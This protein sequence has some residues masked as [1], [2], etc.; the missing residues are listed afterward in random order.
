MFYWLPSDR[1]KIGRVSLI[2]NESLLRS[3]THKHSRLKIIKS[4][5]I[6]HLLHNGIHTSRHNLQFRQYLIHH[7]DYL[8]LTSQPLDQLDHGDHP[9]NQLN[10]PNQP[11]L[12]DLLTTLTHW[13]CFSPKLVGSAGSGCCWFVY[14]IRPPTTD[15]LV[16]GMPWPVTN[17]PSLSKTQL[18]QPWPSQPLKHHDRP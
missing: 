18:W 1:T 10:C 12:P 15:A 3:L 11:N 6:F 9:I 5:Q 2:W 14:Q 7:P 8:M 13:C 17:L 16:T 4:Y